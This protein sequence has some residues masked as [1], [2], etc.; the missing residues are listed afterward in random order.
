MTTWYLHVR[1]VISVMCCTTPLHS[2]RPPV[3]SAVP[4]HDFLTGESVIGLSRG[5]L[6]RG[7]SLLVGERCVGGQMDKAVDEVHAQAKPVL[8]FKELIETCRLYKVFL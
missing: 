4:G 7:T 1:G 6:L 3:L 2:E 5:K 8:S